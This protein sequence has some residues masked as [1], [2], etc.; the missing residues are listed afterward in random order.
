MSRTYIETKSNGCQVLYGGFGRFATGIIIDNP[1]KGK[2]AFLHSVGSLSLPQPKIYIDSRTGNGQPIYGTTN[3]EIIPGVPINAIAFSG[4][5]YNPSCEN[6]WK[7]RRVSAV[8]HLTTVKPKMSVVLALFQSV[9]AGTRFYGNEFVYQDQSKT[10]RIV[11]ASGIQGIE[12][13]DTLGYAIPIS[14]MPNEDR[15]NCS[16]IYP[17]PTYL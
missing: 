8:L 1:T 7:K 16:N 13:D 9:I 3:S 10:L 6:G 2:A 4:F 15:V 12:Q 14:Y 5:K 11:D 17:G